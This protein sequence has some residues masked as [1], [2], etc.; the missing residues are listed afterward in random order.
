MLT[1]VKLRKI[2][3]KTYIY[4]HRARYVFINEEKISYLLPLNKGFIYKRK[5]KYFYR[6]GDQNMQLQKR[7]NNLVTNAE[8][9]IYVAK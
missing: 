4:N 6:I 2:N 7:D 3:N 1:N 8:Q 5:E 9:I